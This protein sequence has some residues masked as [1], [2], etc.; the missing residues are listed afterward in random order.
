[1]FVCVESG[2]M[3]LA[4]KHPQS[5]RT[6]DVFRQSCGGCHGDKGVLVLRNWLTRTEIVRRIERECVREKTVNES[7]RKAAKE[8][9]TLLSALTE[10]SGTENLLWGSFLLLRLTNILSLFMCIYSSLE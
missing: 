4:L 8:G 1:M 3:R 7:R 2:R 9:G 10:C 6:Q 5:F